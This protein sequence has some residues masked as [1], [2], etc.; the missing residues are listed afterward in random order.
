M[1]EEK[2]SYQSK[3]VVINGQ[4]V[5]LYS[6]NGI[7]WLS[8]PDDIPSTMERLE[9]HRI[10]LAD[11][12]GE[13]GEAAKKAAKERFKPRGPRGAPPTVQGDAPVEDPEIFVDGEDLDDDDVDDGPSLTKAVLKPAASSSDE[14]DVVDDDDDAPVRSSKVIPIPTPKM[15]AAGMDDEDVDEIPVRTAAARIEKPVL[16]PEKKA[17]VKAAAKA[18]VAKAAPKAK[19]KAVAGKK[20]GAKKKPAAPAKKKAK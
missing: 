6:A 12:K 13:G 4:P 3:T 20:P 14:D 5:T 7:T 11:P 17:V 8:R 10:T 18:T 16:V 9:N 19:P 2:I 1:S 15:Q